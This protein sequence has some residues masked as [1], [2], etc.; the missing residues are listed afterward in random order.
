MRDLMHMYIADKR[1]TRG[2]SV[3][4]AD[5]DSPSEGQKTSSSNAGVLDIATVATIAADSNHNQDGDAD[6]DP[7]ANCA[8]PACYVVD[9]YEASKW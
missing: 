3:L 1:K 6:E 2:A 8:G 4:V 7:N 9:Y 5:G